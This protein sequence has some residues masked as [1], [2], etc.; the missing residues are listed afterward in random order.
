MLFSNAERCLY[1]NPVTHEVICQLRFP[2]ILSI[3]SRE[4]ADFQDLIRS[5]FPRYMLRRENP[6]VKITPQ[7]GAA[8]RVEQ[9]APISNHTFISADNL[10]KINLTRDFIAL[11][12]LR[13]T[14]WEKFA[15]ALDKTLAAFIRVYQPAFF[16]RIG[17]RYMN[18]ISRQKL[19]LEHEPWSSLIS[20]VYLGPYA[21]EDIADSAIGKFSTDTELSLGGS[22][23]AKIHSGTAVLKPANL[24]VPQDS[25]QK[26][27]LDIDLSM[28]GNIAPHLAA[29]GLET[30]HSHS[31][32]VFRGAITGLLHSAMDPQ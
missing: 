24:S 17:L 26:F 14:G 28:R 29:A 8:P 25:E 9:A 6:P 18:I 1:E 3:E 30:L 11:S 32:R 10:R 20:P 27:I 7:N 16:E 2:T 13:Y 12:T 4:P 19:G 31:T 22:M 21:E 15:A 23:Q 5:D